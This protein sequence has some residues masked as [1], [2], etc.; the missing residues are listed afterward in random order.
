METWKTHV[1][2]LGGNG[3]FADMSR[4]ILTITHLLDEARRFSEQE[5]AHPEPTIFG[6]TD[7]KAIGIY[8]EHKFQSYLV[9]TWK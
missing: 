6:A 4:T 9:A 8:L 7:G 3:K 1:P 5:S 2:L